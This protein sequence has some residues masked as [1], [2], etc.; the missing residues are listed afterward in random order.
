MF[1]RVGTS[2]VDAGCWLLLG[3]CYL[4]DWAAMPFVIA[5]TRWEVFVERRRTRKQP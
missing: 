2:L 1:R 3:L 4:L 5:Y